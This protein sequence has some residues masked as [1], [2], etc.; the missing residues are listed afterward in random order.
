[1]AET[2][3]VTP[4]RVRGYVR[5]GVLSPRR[6]PRGE[7]RFTVQDL[8]LLKTAKELGDRVPQRRLRRALRRLREQLPA[9]RPLAG[10]R[11]TALGDE[12]VVREGPRAWKAETGQGVL[13]FEVA[14]LAAKVAPLIRRA[15]AADPVAT[16]E[17]SA[18]EWF[19]LACEMEPS[20]PG[21]AKGAYQRVLERDPRHADAHLN[22]GRLL[23]E[24]GDARAAETHYRLA[25]AARPGD[26]TAAFNLGVALEDLG[27]GPE[28]IAAYCE[29]VSADPRAADA[30]YNLA[31]L[32]ESA[33]QK[34]SAIRHLKA[35]RAL[36]QR[37]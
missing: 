34:A 33:G 23:H 22:L 8:V 32:Y 24:A 27:R 13:D 15:A 16:R 19:E 5:M 6:G 3:G 17:A 25:L 14:E 9:G 7:Y 10:L 29:A 35:Y 20:D 30:H 36:V 4:S 28:A 11:I 18:Q 21:Q 31:R 26:S 12:V 37:R 1:V 2:L